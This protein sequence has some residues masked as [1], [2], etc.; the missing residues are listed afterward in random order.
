MEQPEKGTKEKCYKKIQEVV[1]AKDK[2][3][4]HPNC[5]SPVMVGH[6]I[7]KRDRSATAFLPEAV[8][9]LCH[10]HHTGW[11]HN[12]PEEFKRFMIERLG[13]RYYELRRL[14]YT[15]LKNLDYQDI[16]ENLVKVLRAYQRGK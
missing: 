14:S 7:F 10:I 16:Y 2:V 6:H 15:T 4:Q 11:A 13:E 12:K 8:I 5:S 3:C 1:A 9:G